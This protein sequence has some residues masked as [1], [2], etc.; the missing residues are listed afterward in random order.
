MPTAKHLLR[1]TKEFFHRYWNL[2]NEQPPSWSKHWDFNS[3]IPNNDK[4]G[5]Y[6]L[7]K[8]EELIYIGVG[9][10]KSFGK[11]HGSGLGDRLKRYW[12]VNKEDESELKYKPTEDWLEL[13]SIMT[14]G[15]SEEHY[16]LAAALE[17]FLINKLNPEKNSQH[18]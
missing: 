9:I 6:A 4:R 14:I 5:C 18:K 2:S 7:F 10:G 3:S 8:N 11:Y 13:T 1:E 17:I 16:S 12:K 15:F